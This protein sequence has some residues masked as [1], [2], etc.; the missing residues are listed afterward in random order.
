MGSINITVS[1]DHSPCLN[2][3][4]NSL[5][6]SYPPMETKSCH[7][8]LAPPHGA[9]QTELR[10][11]ARLGSGL[12]PLA[13]GSVHTTA[14]ARCLGAPGPGPLAAAGSVHT[15]AFAHCLGAPGPGPL[16]AAVAVH[17][18]ALAHCLGAPGPGHFAAASVRTAAL[19]APPPT[20]LKHLDC[21]RSQQPAPHLPAPPPTAPL[22]HRGVL[23]D[24]GRGACTQCRPPSAAA[25]CGRCVCSIM[26]S[27]D[28]RR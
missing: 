3:G 8:A 13:A 16:A 10:Q 17:T 26:D 24:G 15:T 27:G 4:E 14:F 28:H 22:L 5:H 9:A 23:P 7:A 11:L 25:H 1:H 12:G 18:A 2:Q 21:C 6:V 19:P 20:A